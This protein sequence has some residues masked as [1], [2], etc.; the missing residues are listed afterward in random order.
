MKASKILNLKLTAQPIPIVISAKNKTSSRGL[1]TGCLNLIIDNAP[2]IPNERA[3]FPEI[4]LVITNPING[5]RQYV[6][7]FANG[8]AHA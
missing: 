7:T 2:T 3:I 8:L 1:F 4:T 6:V 5:N